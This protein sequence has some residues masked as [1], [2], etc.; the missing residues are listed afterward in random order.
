[1]NRFAPRSCDSDYCLS[2][3][4]QQGDAAEVS[5]SPKA[6]RRTIHWTWTVRGQASLILNLGCRALTPNNGCL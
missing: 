5:E 3:F 6:V 2:R 4:V 1:M